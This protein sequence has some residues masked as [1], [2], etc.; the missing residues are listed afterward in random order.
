MTK[1]GRVIVICGP[2]LTGKTTL[3]GLV[4]EKIGGVLVDVDAERFELLPDSAALID[5]NPTSERQLMVA[6]Y[7]IA[8]AKC[9]FRSAVMQR[10]IVVSGPFSVQEFKRPMEALIEDKIVPVRIFRL[11][12]PEEEI[13]RRLQQRIDSKA[14]VTITSWEKYQ[15]SLSIRVPWRPEIAK[16]VKKI[17]TTGDPQDGLRAILVGIE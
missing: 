2:P 11:D 17:T 7:E 12:A 8:V 6:A 1:S 10:T 15:R 14:K 3:A 9:R 13:R 4:A 5:Q 16:K